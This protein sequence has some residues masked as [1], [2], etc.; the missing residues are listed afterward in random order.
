TPEM[1]SLAVAPGSMRLDTEN[2]SFDPAAVFHGLVADGAG[3]ACHC[4]RR[5]R[6]ADLHQRVVSL[7]AACLQVAT[8]FRSAHRCAS[9]W[10]CQPARSDTG[11]GPTRLVKNLFLVVMVLNLVTLRGCR[12]ERRAAGGQRQYN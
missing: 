5:N 9:R 12:R 1:Q 11:A 4:S 7:V 2:V 10:T 6:R 8:V 3:R